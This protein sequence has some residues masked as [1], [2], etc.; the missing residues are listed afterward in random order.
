SF[1]A[2][3]RDQ[4]GLPLPIVDQILELGHLLDAG[5]AVLAEDRLVLLGEVREEGEVIRLGAALHAELVEAATIALVGEMEGNLVEI[6]VQYPTGD[7]VIPGMEILH[8]AEVGGRLVDALEIAGVL[9]KRGHRL[10]A[11][12]PEEVMIGLLGG[13][14]ALDGTPIEDAELNGGVVNPGF[15]KHAG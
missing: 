7:R 4:R 9:S 13:S 11:L 5:D 14:G 2:G 15:G 10:F 8:G 3:G 12:P 6:L 1:L